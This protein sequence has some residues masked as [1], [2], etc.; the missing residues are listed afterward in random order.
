MQSSNICNR[1]TIDAHASNL[2]YEGKSSLH[3]VSGRALDFRGYVDAAFS[4]DGTLQADPA[5]AMRLEVPVTA[6]RSGSTPKDQEVWRLIDVERSPHIV[7]ELRS[8]ELLYGTT[9]YQAMGEITIAGRTRSY[10]GQML[11]LTEDRQ[12]VSVRGDLEID[13]RHFGLEP[14]RML[15]V[16]IEPVISVHLSLVATLT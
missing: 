4:E 10:D 16:R 15:F 2:T 3:S 9:I 6:L 13:I 11:V 7:A 12:T 1:Y 14:P 5:P 8:I